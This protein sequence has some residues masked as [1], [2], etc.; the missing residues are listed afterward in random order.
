MQRLEGLMARFRILPDGK[1][2]VVV[3][4]PKDAFAEFDGPQLVKHA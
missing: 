2:V 1:P 3:E 4:T